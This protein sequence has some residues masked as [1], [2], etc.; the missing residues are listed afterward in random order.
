[1][2]PELWPGSGIKVPDPDPAKVKDH[3][4]KT[5]NSELFEL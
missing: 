4:N 2:D 5:V 3:I 1:M